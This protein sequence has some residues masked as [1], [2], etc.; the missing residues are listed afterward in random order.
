MG[1]VPATP[2]PLRVAVIGGGIAGLSA[3]EALARAGTEVVLLESAGQVGGKLATGDLAGH[4]I[5]IGAE[6]VLARRPEALDLAQRFGLGPRL[7]HPA[8]AGAY[9]W[10][11]SR[12]RP[13][14]PK[15]VL[16]IPGDLTA[17]ARSQ[18]LTV[19]E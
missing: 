13:L 2:T 4:R 8:A 11:R 12:L 14:P 6:S 18:V 19:R 5:D 17:L 9:V 15:T 10:T 16:G 7:V 3:A 1:A